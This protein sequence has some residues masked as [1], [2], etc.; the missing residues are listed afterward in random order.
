MMSLMNPSIDTSVA[1]MSNAEGSYVTRWLVDCCLSSCDS[2]DMYVEFR[3]PVSKDSSQI[4]SFPRSIYASPTVLYPAG[5]GVVPKGNRRPIKASSSTIA[6]NFNTV[7]TF[8]C[9]LL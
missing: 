7:V 8:S 9:I 1:V 5:A 6:M 4:R 2:K 3:S